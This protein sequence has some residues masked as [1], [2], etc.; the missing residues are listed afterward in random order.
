[1]S[2]LK[3]LQSKASNV[4]TP[5]ATK[6]KKAIFILDSAFFTQLGFDNGDELERKSNEDMAKL[7]S[8]D[9]DI[10]TL[11]GQMDIIK[12]RINGYAKSAFIDS[13]EDSGKQP[14]NFKITSADGES[15]AMFIAQDKYT[16]KDFDAIKQICPDMVHDGMEVVVNLDMFEKYDKV[17]TKFFKTSKDIADADRDNFFEATPKVKIVSG[18]IENLAKY[19]KDAK[20]TIEALFDLVRPVHYCSK[21]TSASKKSTAKKK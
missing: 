14:E 18:T 10:K 21:F 17:L 7:A 2:L 13:Y 4:A 11:T 20:V 6:E 15:T 5:T 3:S 9:A 19:A 1:M 16:G 8:L 12:S